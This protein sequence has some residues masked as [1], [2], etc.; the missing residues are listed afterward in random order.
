MR[1]YKRGNIWWA[2]YGKYGRPRSLETSSQTEARSRADAEFAKLYAS[3]RLGIQHR[4]WSD[5]VVA[6]L[7]ES[8][9]QKSLETTKLRLRWLHDRLDGTWLRDITTAT[10]ER[11]IAEY[12]PNHA[13]ASVN[14]MMA[15]LSAVLHMA[16]RRGWI[17]AVPYIRKLHEDNNVVRW[18]THQQAAE[19][20][21]QLPPHL[22]VM[23]AFTLATG[24]RASNVQYL[25]WSHVD[26]QRNVAWIDS[27]DH[28]SGRAHHVPLNEAA[29]TVLQAQ[30]SLHPA[31]VF[32]YDGKPVDK[33][34]TKAWHAA[35]KR[36]GIE[37]F[38]WHD[39]RHTWASW[40]VMAGTPLEVLMKLGGWQ[41]LEMVMRYAHLAE[42]YTASYAANVSTPGSAY[43]TRTVAHKSS[44]PENA[45]NSQAT[46]LYTGKVGWLMGL[47][48]TTTGITKRNPNKYVCRLLILNEDLKQ[49]AA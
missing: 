43:K 17:D 22:N 36:A 14:R 21:R 47:E 25:Q 33:V 3:T 26:L 31:W 24:L 13:P 32:P 11:L 8:A 46:D 2:N 39:L 40:H 4:T 15:A 1:I 10:V 38:R 16:R 12:Q 29:L 23:A 41:S 18:L 9:A 6:Y 42:Q 27:A 34:S 44:H 7:N 35:L 19:L 45:D 48:P 28:K 30:R 20:L 5:A 37:N 49:N